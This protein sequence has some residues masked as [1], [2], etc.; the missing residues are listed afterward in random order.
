MNSWQ[1]ALAI[2]AAAT[3]IL[4]YDVPRARLW[5]IVGA[6]DFA[7]TTAYARYGLPYPSFFTAI[8]D[9]LVCVAIF[10]IASR[11]WELWL[12]RIFQ[13]MVLVDM[14]YFIAAN[15]LLVPN[16]PHYT[17]VCILE[18]LNWLALFII[19]GTAIFERVWNAG[20]IPRHHRAGYIHRAGNFAHSQRADDPFHKA[21][22]QGR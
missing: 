20:N 18:T 2:A 17:F 6:F 7:V 3:G 14:T 13:A 1:L 15:V 5:I 10:F 8:I 22:K 9:A 4:A 16:P 19:G 21:K 12:M 11:R